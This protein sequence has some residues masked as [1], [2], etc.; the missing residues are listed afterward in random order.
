MGG[1]RNHAKQTLE[2]QEEEMRPGAIVSVMRSR[3]EC[4]REQ[5]ARNIIM[6]RRRAICA[7]EDPDEAEKKYRAAIERKTVRGN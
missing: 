5:R 6:V 3:I 7:G 1:L 2:S 4:D